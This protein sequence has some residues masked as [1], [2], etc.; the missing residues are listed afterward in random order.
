MKFLILLI[1]LSLTLAVPMD[2]IENVQEDS[3]R[4]GVI[5][6]AYV[7]ESKN[8]DCKK[9]V[10]GVVSKHIE[11]DVEF[12]WPVNST[13]GWQVPHEVFG[14]GFIRE[15]VHD[16]PVESVRYWLYPRHA[17]NI[18]YFNH[19]IMIEG[20][21]RDLVI[22]YGEKRVES[23]YGFRVTDIKKYSKL[24]ELLNGTTEHK[25]PLEVDMQITGDVAGD[26]VKQTVPMIG[27]VV[28]IHDKEI[29][30]RWR[31]GYGFGIGRWGLGGLGYGGLGYGGFGYGGLG[32]GYGL[33]YPYGI[34]G[35]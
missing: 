21:P 1:S 20:V 11:C 5:E 29:V 32:Y 30:K 16:E 17:E 9:V 7:P 23:V 18:T 35:R 10:N 12:E 3:E 15:L 34:W 26:V 2:P 14:L 28:I 31:G 27:E 6:C 22:Y 19:R 8:I 33:G 25:I 4:S 24:F 13:E